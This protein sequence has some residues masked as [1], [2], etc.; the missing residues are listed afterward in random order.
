MKMKNR[1]NAN[2]GGAIDVPA[3][4]GTEVT[5]EDQLIFIQ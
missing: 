5:G 2:A 3:L 4:N 1:R